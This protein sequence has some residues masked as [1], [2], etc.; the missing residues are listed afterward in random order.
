MPIKTIRVDLE[1]CYGIK[2]LKQDF[3]FSEHNVYA[4][5]T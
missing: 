1:N 4:L 3:D 5:Y 2:A